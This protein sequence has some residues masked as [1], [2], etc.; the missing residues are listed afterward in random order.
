MLWGNV[1]IVGK[2]ITLGNTDFST[3][4]ECTTTE[5][6]S[7][8]SCSRSEVDLALLSL[9]TSDGQWKREEESAK[10]IAKATR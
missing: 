1:G 3:V 8:E 4:K 9:I 10:Q 6:C 7:Q 2:R 5:I